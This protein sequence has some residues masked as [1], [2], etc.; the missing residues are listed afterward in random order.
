M[1]KNQN[2]NGVL[3]NGQPN[4]PTLSGLTMGLGR[5]SSVVLPHNA[6]LNDV[7]PFRIGGAG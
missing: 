5:L 3:S 4:G 1:N 6:G 7:N 2:P